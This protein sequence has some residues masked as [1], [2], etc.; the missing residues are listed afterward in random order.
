MI[1]LEVNEINTFYGKSHILFDVL[2]KTNRG[3]VACLLGR[4]GAGKTTTL[5]TIMGLI[6]PSSG[7]IIYKGDPIQGKPA[8]IIARAGIGY[9]PEAR[10]IFPD[11]TVH[12]NLMISHKKP[13]GGKDEYWT[14]EKV[15]DLFPVL[16]NRTNW[17]GAQ[18]SGGEQQML[19]IARALMGNPELILM[20]E[21]TEGLAPLIRKEVAGQIKLL[22]SK[23]TSIVLA[24][25]N[26]EFAMNI[27]HHAYIIE[28]GRI[29]YQGTVDQLRENEEMRRRYLAA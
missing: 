8:F 14:L 11:L 13:I 15:Y 24:E 26:S 18:L 9:V 6:H 21:P 19:S 27:C 3:E 16:K 7:T 28:K 23:G 17:R 29:C 20:D 25:Q 1:I 5:K 12:E 4:N 2:F 22:N 10:E